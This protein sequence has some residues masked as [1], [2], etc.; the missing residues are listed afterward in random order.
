[1]RDP[2]NWIDIVV[3][4]FPMLLLIGVWIWFM[5]Q[6]RGK[7]G[8]TQGQYFEAILEEYKKQNAVTNKLLE[9]MDQRLRRLEDQDHK[10]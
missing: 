9:T 5:R 8:L 10:S 1:M 3:S 2:M 4:W 6:M 7:S